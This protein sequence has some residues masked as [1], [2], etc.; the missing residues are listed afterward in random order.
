MENLI[1]IKNGSYSDIKKALTQWIELYAD[2]LQ[3]DFTF[4]LFKNGRGNHVIQAD[5][6]LDNTRFYYLVNY[7]SYPV[8]I[9]FLFDVEGFTTGKDD[10]QLK[11][12]RLSVYIFPTDTEYDNVFVTTSD[13]ENFKVDFGGG[14]TRVNESR[15]YQPPPELKLENPEVVKVKQGKKVQERDLGGETALAKRFNI[16]A[17]I[18]ISLLFVGYLT[19]YIDPSFFRT[20][21]IA[22]GAALGM[23]FFADH[24][25]L[26]SNKYYIYCLGIAFGYLAMIVL[27]LNRLDRSVADYGAIYPLSLLLVQKPTQFLFKSVIKREPIVDTPPRS[28]WDVIYMFILLLGMTALPFIILDHLLR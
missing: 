28:F 26:R 17:A 8:G 15:T 23:W 2:D 12:K 24:V 5:E 22:L 20:F 4:H 18:A 9:E 27:I 1:L 7:L 10:D 19:L 25:M 16:L 3:S 6:R 21:S 13:N 11:D 14:I